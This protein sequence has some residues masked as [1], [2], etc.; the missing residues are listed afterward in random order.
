MRSS[1]SSQS[2]Q[3]RYA[4]KVWKIASANIG[5]RLVKIQIEEENHGDKFV[6]SSTRDSATN[7]R[8]GTDSTVIA[9][10]RRLPGVFFACRESRNEAFKQNPNLRLHFTAHLRYPILFDPIQDT[11]LLS[12]PDAFMSYIT[13]KADGCR[14][15]LKLVHFLTIETQQVRVGRKAKTSYIRFKWEPTNLIL[16][17]GLKAFP[18]YLEVVH[19]YSVRPDS[20]SSW[21]KLC[22]AWRSSKF[23]SSGF[24]TYFKSRTGGPW[25]KKKWKI[26]NSFKYFRFTYQE[27]EKHL[28]DRLKL[29][30]SLR[31][32]EEHREY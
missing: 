12:D 28:L 18:K 8:D 23:I 11:L 20:S 1:H 21:S 14:S 15:D 3:Q 6:G 5:A 25:E 29:N 17:H 2:S 9:P 19:L 13:A 31:I 32:L 26:L 24:P 27:M 4:L 30:P 10:A 7:A 22:A 16:D